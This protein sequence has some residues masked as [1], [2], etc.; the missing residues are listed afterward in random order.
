VVLWPVVG[1]ACNVAAGRSRYSYLGGAAAGSNLLYWNSGREQGAG[2]C[3]RAKAMLFCSCTDAGVGCLY[4]SGPA[5]LRGYNRC[6][7]LL[8]VLLL[9]A[10]SSFRTAPAVDGQERWHSIYS[11]CTARV[12]HHLKPAAPFHSWLELAKVPSCATRLANRTGRLLGAHCFA[13][14]PRG[15]RC[16]LPYV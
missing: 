6:L 9:G 10:G 5:F 7:R 1:T 11:L 16:S 14:T 2:A 8:G 15:R 12:L 13:G 4:N 3:Y